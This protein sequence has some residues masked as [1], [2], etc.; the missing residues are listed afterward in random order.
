MLTGQRVYLGARMTRAGRVLAISPD[1]FRRLMSSKPSIAD[2]IFRAFVARRELLQTGAGSEAVRI[3]GSRYS[4]RRWRCASFAMRRHFPHSW[5]D[6][7]DAEDGD[8]LLASLG[9]RA[10]DTPVVITPN[11]VLL[12][13]TP[14]EFAEHLGP[15]VP[16][17]AG[18]PV[19]SRRGRYRPGGAGGRGVRRVGGPRHRV[20]RRRRDRRPGRRELAHRELRRVPERHLRRGAG[21]ARGDPGATARCA[22]QRPVRGRGPAQSRTAST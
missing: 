5:I 19:R 17:R 14:G 3:I 16:R 12:H 15:H 9:I 21:D 8:V 18:L 11:G 4:R 22:A 20:A 13:P 10:R 7:E 6:L 1:E 2:T